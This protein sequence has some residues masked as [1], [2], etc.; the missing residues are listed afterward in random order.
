MTEEEIEV[1]A[2]EL[3][4]VGGLPWYPGR[5]QGPLLRVVSN[6]YRDR[7]RVAITALE[8][9]RQGTQD[10][11][12]SQSHPSDVTLT[13]KHHE[14]QAPDTLQIGSIV[15]YRPPGDRR[16]VACRVEKLEEGRA[17]LVPCT[18]PDIGWVGLDPLQPLPEGPAPAEG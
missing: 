9:L 1:V 16:A 10:R 15:V 7:A 12:T 6:R 3:A 13:N 11:G 18:K 2:E 8:R 14:P 5:T 17:Y 4:K